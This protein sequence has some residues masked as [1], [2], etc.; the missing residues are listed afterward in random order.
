LLYRKYFIDELYRATAVRAMIAF[1]RLNAL[2]D[3]W[4]IDGI[5]NAAGWMTARFSWLNGLIDTYIVDGVVNGVGVITGE[6]AR[7]LRLVQT[8][9]VQNY[10]LVVFFSV[11]VLVGLFLGL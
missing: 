11:L 10:L 7:G 2:I 1:S 3:Q 4:I 5:V 9:R 6:M 8:G